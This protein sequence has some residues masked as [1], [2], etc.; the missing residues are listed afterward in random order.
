VYED[1]GL[2]YG[3]GQ[4]GQAMKVG[5]Q[6]TSVLLAVVLGACNTSENRSPA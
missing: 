3:R 4:F 5:A 6:Q 1:V 2:T